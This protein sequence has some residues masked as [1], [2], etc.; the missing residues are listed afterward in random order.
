MALRLFQITL[1]QGA[2]EDLRQQLAE[3]KLLWVWA[4]EMPEDRVLLQA[5]LPLE[6]SQAVLDLLQKDYGSL[7]G[8]QVVV[9]PV[10]ASWPLEGDESESKEK[11]SS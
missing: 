5:L 9:L 7:E 11:L 6:D 8:V 10:E 4:Q 2:A 3:R 1:P